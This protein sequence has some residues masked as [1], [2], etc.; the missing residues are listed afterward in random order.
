MLDQLFL[1]RG[2]CPVMYG[3]AEAVV[4]SPVMA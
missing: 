3:G 4:I 1:P 2:N